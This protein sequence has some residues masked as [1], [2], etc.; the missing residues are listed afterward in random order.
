M[1]IAD[2]SLLCKRYFPQYKNSEQRVYSVRRKGFI[3]AS[4]N[5]AIVLYMKAFFY[6]SIASQHQQNIVILKQ[7]F[8]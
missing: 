1:I 3:S 8:G 4:A 7:G 5:Q 6:R 2:Y